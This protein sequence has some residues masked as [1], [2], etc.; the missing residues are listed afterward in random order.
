MKGNRKPEA[1]L[2]HLRL[3]DTKDA[4]TR[5]L[6]Y[7]RLVSILRWALP[8]GVALALIVVIAVPM[9]TSGDI[10]ELA[11]KHAPDLMVE[12]L[13]LKGLDSHNQ[14][15]SLTAVRALQAQ[16]A[17]NK[18]TVDLEKPKAEI[19]LEG[20]DWIAG[21]AQEGRFDQT[22]QTLW[23]G[24]SVEFF[25]D[26]GYR[27]AS[28]EF[29][30]DMGKKVGWSEKP[31][32]IQGSFGE[33]RGQGLRLLNGGETIVITGHATAK[34]DLQPAAGPDKPSGKHSTAQ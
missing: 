31:V 21:Q 5:S 28:D 29:R 4:H 22:N 20:G 1:R 16:D 27:I 26:K 10:A 19:S 12:D 33:I 6:A 7:S 8:L 32:L 14:A 11:A 3:R 25:H 24:G 15:Y 9:M 30:F 13:Q 23:L 18:N 34:L 2:G 17:A